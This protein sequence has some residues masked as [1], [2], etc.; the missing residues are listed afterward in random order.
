LREVHLFWHVVLRDQL[1]LLK[2]GLGLVT[3]T[4]LNLLRTTRRDSLLYSGS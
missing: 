2:G 4:H 1:H 3:V